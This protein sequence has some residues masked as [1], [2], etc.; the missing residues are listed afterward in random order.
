MIIGIVLIRNVETHRSGA[1]AEMRAFG[2]L[3]APGAQSNARLLLALIAAGSH[4]RDIGAADST[5]LE[6]DQRGELSD[7]ADQ[8]KGYEEV[9]DVSDPELDDSI[10]STEP[11]L[12]PLLQNRGQYLIH[13]YD[14]GQ[15]AELLSSFT[16][17]ILKHGIAVTID[18]DVTH[19]GH[20]V[21]RNFHLCSLN[22]LG[23]L[24]TDLTGFPSETRTLM[25]LS[26]HK[27]PMSGGPNAEPFCL[28][29]SPDA[30]MEQEKCEDFLRQVAENHNFTL[31]IDFRNIKSFP[32]FV[33]FGNKKIEIYQGGSLL[34]NDNSLKLEATALY[35]EYE[36]AISKIHQV[37]LMYNKT[38][39]AINCR[40]SLSELSYE[41]LQEF[42]ECV[43][44][45]VKGRQ[46]RG[47]LE[48]LGLSPDL[49][50]YIQ[51]ANQVIRANFAAINRNEALITKA[52]EYDSE[53]IRYFIEKESKNLDSF[54]RQLKY[55]RATNAIRELS[56]HYRIEAIT[57]FQ[58][59]GIALRQMS[60]ELEEL[61]QIALSPVSRRARVCLATGTCI[62]ARSIITNSSGSGVYVSARQSEAKMI[63]VEKISCKLFEKSG[64]IYKHGM[65]TTTCIKVKGKLI[66]R[67]T[68][69]LVTRECLKTAKGCP[70]FYSEVTPDDLI[71]SVMYL[72]LHNDKLVAQC[73]EPV[74]ID[75]PGGGKT[76]CNMI[77]IHVKFPFAIKGRLIPQHVLHHYISGFSQVGH[78]TPGETEMFENLPL[79]TD[80]TTVEKVLSH[81][82]RVYTDLDEWDKQ[83]TSYLLAAIL[84][85]MVALM[86]ISCCCCPERAKNCL[87]ACCNCWQGACTWTGSALW[88]Q[89]TRCCSVLKRGRDMLERNAGHHPADLNMGQCVSPGPG[90]SHSETP[91]LSPLNSPRR[92]GEANV[93]INPQTVIYHPNPQGDTVETFVNES[94]SRRGKAGKSSNIVANTTKSPLRGQ[95]IQKL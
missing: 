95:N 80:D 67:D 72:S 3:W 1:V 23:T 49:E 9:N 65:D 76:T 8:F 25:P 66:A 14:S 50:G 94:K 22:I 16:N 88:S 41:Q 51:K 7:F 20:F 30:G 68:R 33:A 92:T 78:L 91:M 63:K 6:L 44:K 12:L 56:E 85:L 62:D 87:L 60:N 48:L 74:S 13:R 28:N 46:K 4:I 58:S 86:I 19:S 59:V 21:T 82:T 54:V 31:N 90:S 47:L 34:C 55:L 35:K 2:Y 73:V 15:V 61:L 42:A 81:L 36:L 43:S 18:T 26:I 93:N 77:P 17:L 89:A 57:A 69:E 84:I 38:A 64:T 27:D 10:C 45:S 79:E 40:H 70:K 83:T 5:G 71:E 53:R 24:D 75:L 11:S 37:A 32:S 39:P 52:L 29:L